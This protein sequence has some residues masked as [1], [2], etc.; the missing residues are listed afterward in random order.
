MC[1]FLFITMNKPDNI[2]ICVGRQLGSGGH[3]IAKQLAETFDC[4]LYDREVLELAAQQSGFS[5][6]VF[7]QNDEKKGFFESMFHMHVPFVTDGSFYDNG[8][9]QENL[10]RLQSDAIRKAADQESGVFVGRFEICL[11]QCCGTRVVR[12]L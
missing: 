3:I 7:E 1:F 12:R 6:K 10:F 2:I 9:S 11:R 4:K 5:T 8:L